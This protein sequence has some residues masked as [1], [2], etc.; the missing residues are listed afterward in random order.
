MPIVPAA[1]LFDLANGGDKDWPVNP[2]RALGAA[3]LAAAAADF[4]LGSAGAGTGAMTASLKGGLGSASLTLASGETVGALVAVNAFGDVDRARRAG[5]L[6]RPFEIG[7]EFGGL[8]PAARRVPP[9]LPRRKPGPSPAGSTTPRSR[10]SRPTPGST[11]RRRGGWPRRRR[12][13]W[14]GRSCPRIPSATATWCSRSRPGRAEVPPML[15]TTLGHAAALCLSRAVAR[16]VHA[17]TPAPG[18]RLPCWSE[19]SA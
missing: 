11:R 3:A 16:A 6:G 19:Y 12:T 8:G 1:I 17:A 7:D 4:A 10:S 14:P 15:R 18:D 5:V 13:A 2:Y 9:G